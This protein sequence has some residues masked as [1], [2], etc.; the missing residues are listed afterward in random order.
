MITVR[1]SAPSVDPIHLTE[2]KNHL[3]V[4]STAD[5]TL[6]SGLIRAAVLYCED[7]TGRALVAQTFKSYLDDIP[8]TIELPY[9]PVASVD[10][11][12]YVDSTG[13]TQTI[14]TTVYTVDTDSEPARVYESYGQVWPTPRGDEKSVTVQWKAGYAAQIA[15]INTTSNVITIA[16]RALTNQAVVRAANSGGSLP[17]GLSADT[18]YYVIEASGQ[19][20]KLCTTAGGTTAVDITSTG[21]GSNFLGVA[22]RGLLQAIMLLVGHWYEHREAAAESALQTVPMAVDALLWQ[23][24]IRG[25]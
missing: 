16:G 12:V 17:G 23:H 4:T 21:S 1:S 15:S 10:S 22:P 18:D 20:V 8:A 24:R 6:I 14:A 9:S 13:S 3:R 25:I 7:W 5:D 19:T 11:I 2:V